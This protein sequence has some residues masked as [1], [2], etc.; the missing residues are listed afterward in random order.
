MKLKC[1]TQ[2]NY[3]ASYPTHD[4]RAIAPPEGMPVLTKYHILCPVEIVLNAPMPPKIHGCCFS[5]ECSAVNET[6]DLIDVVGDACL[7]RSCARPLQDADGTNTVPVVTSGK[8][9]K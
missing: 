5:A 3:H 6:N 4:L 8:A 1:I 7:A 2:A 9:G